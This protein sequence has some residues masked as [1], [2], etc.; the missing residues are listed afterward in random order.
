MMTLADL[1]YKSA[2]TLAVAAWNTKDEYHR[3]AALHVLER[4]NSAQLN[5]Y[6]ELAS[7]DAREHIV[8][9]AKRIR[10]SNR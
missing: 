9:M 10:E 5:E 8:A 1:G 4:L 3:M 7:A 2:E 6:L